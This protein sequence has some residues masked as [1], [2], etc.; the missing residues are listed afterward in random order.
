LPSQGGQQL[1]L[2][3]LLEQQK[4]VQNLEAT[5][6]ALTAQLKEQATQIQKVS[7][8]LEAS[9]TGPQIVLNNH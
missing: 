4:K 6:A 7:A 2:N 3:D 5:V 1:S 8:Q 9:R